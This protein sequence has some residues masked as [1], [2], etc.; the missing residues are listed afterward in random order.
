MGQAVALAASR[1]TKRIPICAPRRST[2]MIGRLC[3][4]APDGVTTARACRRRAGA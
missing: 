2:A 1:A 4:E 3:H